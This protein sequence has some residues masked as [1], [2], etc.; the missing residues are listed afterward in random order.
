M[1][2]DMHM[3]HA[4]HKMYEEIELFGEGQKAKELTN[5]IKQ[6]AI[7]ATATGFIPV[8]GLDVLAVVANIWTMYV[9]INDVVGVSFSEN[10]L[11]SIA[12]GVIAN[13]A[14]TI[15]AIALTVGAGSLLKLLPGIG[16]AGGIAIA[17][18]A[19]IAVIYVAGKV[20]L[21]SLEVLLQSGKPLTEENLKEVVTQMSKDKDF[22]KSAYNEGEDVAKNKIDKQ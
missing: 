21:K 17:V 10:V 11:K 22:V 18:T 6:H 3:A 20:Y 7:A 9:R 19:N 15:P 14:S 4:V 16:T 1:S 12:S 5:V 13:L 8:P 2:N